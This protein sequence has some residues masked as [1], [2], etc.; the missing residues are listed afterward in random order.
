MSDPFDMRE[1]ELLLE[2]A[3]E[4]GYRFRQFGGEAPAAGDLFLRH[5]VDLSLDAAD[6]LATNRERLLAFLQPEPVARR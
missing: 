3:Q 5:D 4:G 2:A 1:Y 6:P